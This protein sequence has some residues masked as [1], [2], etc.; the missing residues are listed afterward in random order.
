[1][2]MDRESTVARLRPTWAEID[3]AAFSRNVAAVRRRLPQGSRLMAVL[4]ADGYGHGAVELARTATRSGAAMIA[5]AL[6]EE[7]LELRAAGIDAPILVLGPIQP[8]QIR[9]ATER[10]LTLGMVG[11]VQLA[12]V[13]GTGL[14]VDI[15]LKLD[16]GMGR[17]GL[18]ESELSMAAELLRGSPRVRLEAIYTHFANASDPRDPLTK[19]QQARFAVMLQKLQDL[20][21]AAPI[22]HSAN[23]PATMRGLV[24]PGDFARVGMS[25]LG[26]EVLE[27][28]P[29]RL[30]P[31]LRWRTEVVRIKE[32]PPGSAIGYGAAFRTRRT[33]RIAVL[34]VG[35][36]D[37]YPRILSEGGEVLLRGKRA[38]V[39]GRISMDLVTIDVTDIDG[40]AHGDEVIL[41][42]RQ[43]E[44]EI[45][46][47]ELAR[48]TSTIAYEVFC[49]ISAR[50]PRVYVGTE[51]P[52]VQSKF[53]HLVSGSV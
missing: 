27:G 42:G 6:L 16:T 9:L 22:H 26:G 49:R 14:E 40:A 19:E 18:L 41:L 3:L 33:S 50:V 1:M 36:A 45:S 44:D 2:S 8:E 10:K 25:L 4:K 39:A 15:H 20:G 13:A 43:G 5:V 23:S 52:S 28:E 17:M 21:V 53:L 30:E 48:R 24:A 34:P 46:A 31:V 7:A 11:P 47:E 32:L 12:E 38:P 51:S 29:A 35:Y 37:G